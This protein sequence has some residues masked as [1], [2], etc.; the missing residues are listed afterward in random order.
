M[1]NYNDIYNKPS[2]NGIEL[3]GNIKIP[4]PTPEEILPSVT[5]ADEGKVLAVDSSGNWTAQE[6]PP[7]YSTNATSTNAYTTTGTEEEE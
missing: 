3:I 2:I 6:L 4:V 1:T 7:I 5:P